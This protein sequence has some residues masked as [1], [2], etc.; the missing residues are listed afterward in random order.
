MNKFVR[1][2]TISAVTIGLFAFGYG[3]QSQV[4]V[5][6]AEQFYSV[7]DTNTNI[8]QENSGNAMASYNDS[9]LQSVNTNPPAVNSTSKYVK[10][11]L[12]MN[13]QNPSNSYTSSDGSNTFNT[14]Y[15]LPEGFHVKSTEHGNYQSSVQVGNNIYV[16]ESMGTGT[17][18]G[19]IVRYNMDDLKQLGVLNADGSSGDGRDLVWKALKYISPYTKS[20]NVHS[21]QYASYQSFLDD[22]NSQLKSN[23]NQVQ[24]AQDQADSDQKEVD[25]YQQTLDDTTAKTNA[26]IKQVQKNI[27]VQYKADKKAK[28]NVVKPVKLTIDN[29]INYFTSVNAPK[30]KRVNKLTDQKTDLEQQIKGLK[31]VYKGKVKPTD[32]SAKDD[33]S[34]QSADSSA[35]ASSAADVTSSSADSKATS[36]ADANSTKASDA[37]ASDATTKDSSADTTSSKAS[38]DKTTTKV[39]KMTKKQYVAKLTPLQTK[40]TKLNQ[41]IAQTKQDQV[42][43]NNYIAEF[44]TKWLSKLT[45]DKQNVADAKD[46]VDQD[47][48]SVDDAKQAVT[49]SQ[50]AITNLQNNVVDYGKYSAIAHAA[51]ISPLI[52]IGHGQTLSYNPV[53]KNLYLAQDDTTGDIAMNANNV[54]TELDANSLQPIKQFN[55]QLLHNNSNYGI[56]TLTFD[57]N[58]NA[59]F[60]R[61]SGKNYIIFKGQFDE[62]SGNVSFAPVPQTITWGGKHNQGLTYNPVNNKLYIVSDDI[63]TSVPVDKLSN[64]TVSPSDVYQLAFN[65]GREFEDVTFDSQG[66]G[67]L[68]ALWKPEIM[69]STQP[70]K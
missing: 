36:S 63:I 34:D 41:Q 48:Q 22:A 31:A 62:N 70:M 29:Y 56:H 20:G 17:N 19:A 43:A 1:W 21:S 51:Q 53:T 33:S 40:L 59:Y 65:S 27:N 67:Y 54:V 18:Q 38:D 2:G 26:Y 9:S 32:A 5:S 39:K 58:G 45:T 49:D 57:N 8:Q 15:Y 28:K 50:T 10:T 47:N 61:K 4:S 55:F 25:E 60:G 35:D 69:K 44:K 14:Y 6:A 7:P 11:S 37:S 66:Y 68:L 46:L 23:Q 42:A 52:N 24:N 30:I 12:N 13:A 16:V 3:Y 64:G